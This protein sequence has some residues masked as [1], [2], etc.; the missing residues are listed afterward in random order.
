M[1]SYLRSTEVQIL[2]T[3]TGESNHTRAHTGAGGYRCS[4]PPTDPYK[5]DQAML[6]R[7][8]SHLGAAGAPAAAAAEPAPQQ[9]GL[10]PALFDEFQRVG[11]VVLRDLLTPAEVARLASPIHDGFKNHLYEGKTKAYPDPSARYS[12][13]SRVLLE[14]PDVAGVSCDH[15]KIIGNT[16][17]SNLICFRYVSERLFVLSA[18]VEQLLGGSAVLS[19]YQS[20][21][22]PA[23]TQH[24]LL[25]VFF[26]G[27][28]ALTICWCFCWCLARLRQC[29]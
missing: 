7:V 6:H 3:V 16:P 20:Y 17:H 15:P 27:N 9:T 4:S 22:S 29:R 1:I 18:A 23:S 11:F 24:N 21:L 19:Q 14:S 13:G 12:L 5:K 8:A 2:W 10:T 28:I 26:S 25:H